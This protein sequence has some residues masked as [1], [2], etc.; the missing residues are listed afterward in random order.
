M[1]DFKDVLNY[2]SEKNYL[3]EEIGNDIV[4]FKNVEWKDYYEMSDNNRDIMSVE[5]DYD[6]MNRRVYNIIL[7]RNKKVYGN[8]N[9]DKLFKN[10]LL[11][12]IGDDKKVLLS[13][14]MNKFNNKSVFGLLYNFRGGRWSV[15]DY[16]D[17]FENWCR[18]SGMLVKEIINDS[19]Y[20]R[21]WL[22]KQNINREEVIYI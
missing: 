13:E 3:F 1:K 21:R 15:N 16:S 12:Y 19:S 14:F 17:R 10:E 7:V 9:M 6:Y 11:K 5:Y 8:N 2:F 22:V 4:V 20:K 18:R